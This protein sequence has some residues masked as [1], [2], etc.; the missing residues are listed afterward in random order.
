MIGLMCGVSNYAFNGCY[1]NCW[2]VRGGV[3]KVVDFKPLAPHRPGRD[4]H[5]GFFY[6]GSYAASSLVKISAI[7]DA[8]YLY[9]IL[10]FLIDY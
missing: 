1:K 6:S 9:F 10:Y 8:D 3:V 7:N 5:Q 4:F 2:D